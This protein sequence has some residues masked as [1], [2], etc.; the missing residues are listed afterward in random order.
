M[1]TREELHNEEEQARQKSSD[2]LSNAFAILD[3]IKQRKKKPVDEKATTVAPKIVES[4][5]LQQPTQ[6]ETR[7]LAKE[8]AKLDDEQ[9]K[10]LRFMGPATA[11]K[12]RSSI[13]APK[14]EIVESDKP[15]QLAQVVDLPT[16]ANPEHTIVA[17]PIIRNWLFAP[18]RS[19]LRMRRFESKI[20]HMGHHV[21]QSITIGD[22]LADAK[23][24]Y[25]VLKVRHQRVLFALQKLWQKQG[26]RLVS[27]YGDK[28]AV[29]SATS[30]AIED[31]LFGNH[32]G[33]NRRNV[34]KWV[35]ELSSIPVR[36]DNY[37]LPNGNLG[38][39]DVTGLIANATFRS[40]KTDSKQ[41]GFPWVEILLSSAVTA[42]FI[43][44]DIKRINSTIVDELGDIAALL[45]PKLDYYLSKH[46]RTTLNLLDLVDK[47]GLSDKQLCER[48]YR[49]R[50]FEA[51]ADELDARRL[52]D[53]AFLMGVWLEP[54]SDNTDYKL[55]A[56]RFLT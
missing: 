39:I 4:D 56:Q 24:G 31:A 7:V 53:E 2:A 38:S 43:A 37:I 54:T 44:G 35:Q 51:V 29:V 41:L 10:G 14:I 18:D 33:R 28:H 13:S 55:V 46:R 32:C 49:L 23:S 3:A 22:T 36:I 26:G 52:S 50:K 20:T 25:G 16:P 15:Q 9:Q 19:K 11:A 12:V 34:R 30:W 21:T 17:L 40:E 27:L 48:L 1:T 8:E 42:S 5:E 47:L 6:V 45:Y